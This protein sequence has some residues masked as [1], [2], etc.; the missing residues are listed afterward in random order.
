VQLSPLRQFILA[1]VLWLPASFFLWAVFASPIV[2]PVARIA[3]L[4]LTGWLPQ[5]VSG[6]LHNVAR[7]E[8]ETRL[9]T[10]T[11]ARAGLIVLEVNPLIYAWC[12]PLFAGLVMATPVSAR[13]RLLQFAIGLPV[14]WLVASWGAVFDTLKLL[15][16]DAGPLGRG[17]LA[18]RGL[19]ADA[20]A[21]G[22]QFG[23][24][25]L[26]A[27]TP[28]ALWIVMNQRFLEALLGWRE[29][30]ESAT[31]GTTAPAAATAAAEPGAPAGG[32]STA[33]T[34]PGSK[35]SG[36]AGSGPVDPAPPGQ[37][38]RNQGGLR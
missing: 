17:A 1:A 10:G 22:Y 8:V 31:V 33:S 24:L 15:M 19:S 2:W 18:A 29:D 14:L 21:L 3:D 20:I 9:L 38:P 11:G 26:P 30:D 25:I 27:V 13:R 12:L 5:V 23:Y 37:A 35:G 32:P 7:L 16:F 6:V 34:G 4:V 28:V 36:P